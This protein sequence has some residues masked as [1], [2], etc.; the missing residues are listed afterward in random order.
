MLPGL[1]PPGPP[2]MTR[3]DHSNLDPRPSSS[4][5]HTLR[6]N[7]SESKNVPA[8]NSADVRTSIMIVG[9]GLFGLLGYLGCVLALF[10]RRSA[11]F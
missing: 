4:H 3:V 1:D 2:M 7:K 6:K 5:L 9:L 11:L 8:K 10:A